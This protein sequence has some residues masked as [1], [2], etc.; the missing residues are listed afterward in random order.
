M[1]NKTS[2][3]LHR[4]KIRMEE[5]TLQHIKHT[6][7]LKGYSEKNTNKFNSLQWNKKFLKDTS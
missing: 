5:G 4:L 3:L 7:F 1:E 6:I 2:W